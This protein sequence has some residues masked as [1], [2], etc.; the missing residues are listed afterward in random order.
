MQ[1]TGWGAWVR[2]VS[3]GMAAVIEKAAEAKTMN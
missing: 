1:L 3:W 2:P